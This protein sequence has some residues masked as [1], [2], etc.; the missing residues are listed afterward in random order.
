MILNLAPLFF[1]LTQLQVSKSELKIQVALGSL[2]KRARLKIE[3][4]WAQE[5]GHCVEHCFI[6]MCLAWVYICSLHIHAPIQVL[7]LI[8]LCQLKVFLLGCFGCNY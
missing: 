2:L 5:S 8:V 3:M 6:T 1:N 4:S 7:L